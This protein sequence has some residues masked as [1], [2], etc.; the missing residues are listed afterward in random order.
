VFKGGSASIQRRLIVLIS[1]VSA[2]W[3]VFKVEI[4][5]RRP[6]PEKGRDPI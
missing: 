3:E 5:V 6:G 2:P 4:L 1:F